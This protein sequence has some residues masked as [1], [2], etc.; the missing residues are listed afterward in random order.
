MKTFYTRAAC[1]ILGLLFLAISSVVGF[2]ATWP[3]TITPNSQKEIWITPGT[4]GGSGTYVS[5]YSVATSSDFDLLMAQAIASGVQTFRLTPGTFYTKG[6]YGPENTSV[7]SKWCLLDGMRF[8]GSGTTNTILLRDNSELISSTSSSWYALYGATMIGCLGSHIEVSDL[9]VD[10][11]AITGTYGGHYLASIAAVQ[12]VHG[13]IHNFCYSAFRNILATRSYGIAALDGYGSEC[14][15]FGL[16]GT[17]FG[18]LVEHCIVTNIVVPDPSIGNAYVNG[19]ATQGSTTFRDCRVYMPAGV[20]FGFNI[21]GGNGTLIERCYVENAFWGVYSD[22]WGTTN[23]SILNSRFVNT[24]GGVKIHSTVSTSGIN[25]IDNLRICDN[26]FELPSSAPGVDVWGIGID[27]DTNCSVRNLKIT[28]NTFR[29]VNDYTEIAN[30]GYVFSLQ[31]WHYAYDNLTFLDN[32][33]DKRM[34]VYQGGESHSHLGNQTDTAPTIGNNTL[35][36]LTRT[37]EGSIPPWDNHRPANPGKRHLITST[38]DTIAADDDWVA[39]R[40]SGS[41][42]ISL[43]TS[44]V[45]DWHSITVVNEQLSGSGTVTV[46]C[47]SGTIQPTA[48]F[49][50]PNDAFARFIYMGSGYWLRN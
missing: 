25:N 4:Q 39:V 17:N 44:G 43:P 29:Y 48:S 32:T 28:G 3:P 35:F 36:L 46:N 26:T 42:T 2:A 40:L 50:L 8:I 31:D 23:C 10:C 14:F 27:N 11:N 16:G 6:Y 37:L 45:L 47:P 41:N 20:G 30:H 7:G 18:A 15:T 21:A 13:E 5:P 33:I 38:S 24:T 34:L 49:S 1:R 12:L 22:S 19:F 9:T